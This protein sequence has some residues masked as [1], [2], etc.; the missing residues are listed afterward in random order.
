MNKESRDVPVERYLQ[1][2]L[3]PDSP[4]V[5]DLH[6]RVEREVAHPAISLTG[7]GDRGSLSGNLT[8]AMSSWLSDHVARIRQS[9][10]SAVEARAAQ[11][12]LRGNVEGI[13]EEIEEDR[14]KRSRNQRRFEETSGYYERHGE[15]LRKLHEVEGE[16][17]ALKTQEGGRD[18]RVPSKVADY[19][20]PAVIMI[21]EFF[22][23][24]ASFVKLAGVPAIGFGLSMVVALAVAVS[25]YMTG[26]FWK[27]FHFYMHPDDPVQ[28]AKGL[29]RIGIATALLLISICA[30]AYARY[31]MVMEQVEAAL[32]I[33]MVPPNAAALTAG[34]LAGN[35]LVFAIGAAV[36]YLMHDENPAFAEKAEVY[37]KLREEAEATRRKQLDA[38]LDGIEGGYKRD[39]GRMRGVAKLMN[40]EADYLPICEMIGDIAA[41]DAEV[42]GAL[43]NYRTRLADRLL[44]TNPDFR[45]AGP[46]TDRYVARHAGTVSIAE[47]AALPLHLYRSN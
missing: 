47:F 43:Q 31:H 28:R 39:Q 27:A 35:L 21:P 5:R 4:A 42:V 25:S 14:L 34:L 45:F 12:R 15:K 18:A 11:I 44:R 46:V 8:P 26:T 40:A 2:D 10:L 29:R 23:N 17:L 13:C 41:K 19:G 32:A 9:A 24:Y 37:A 16:Y 36:T 1:I 20:I 6:E 22:M 33:G 7:D 30:V 38:K 3:S